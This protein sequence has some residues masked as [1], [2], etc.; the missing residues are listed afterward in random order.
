MQPVPCKVIERLLMKDI[1]ALL[2][3]KSTK[4]T[5]DKTFEQYRIEYQEDGFTYVFWLED[6]ATVKA[7][8]DLAKKYDIAGVAAWRLGYDQSDLWK[9]DFAK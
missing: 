9:I 2:A 5:W 4:Q 8:L 1:P 3:S 7:R 6:E